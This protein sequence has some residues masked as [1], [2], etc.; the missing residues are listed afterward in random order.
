MNETEPA[1]Q[2]PDAQM[3]GR[4]VSHFEIREHLGRGGRGV[5][6]K[7]KDQKLDRWVALKFL[8]SHVSRDPL[9][10]KRMVNEARMASALD[11]PNICTIHAIDE[12]ADGQLFIAMAFY[13]GETL[14]ARI[15]RGPLSIAEIRDITLQ[16][17]SGLEAAHDRGIIH[18]DIKPANLML[19][20]DGVV[21][22]LDFGLSKPLSS[23]SKLT[24][25]GVLMGTIAYMSP[26]QAQGEEL[27]ARTDIWS[28]GVVLFEMATGRR[29]FSGNSELAVLMGIAFQELDPL[30]DAGNLPPSLLPVVTRAL[31]KD[32]DQRYP[33][34]AAMA[35][36][37]VSLDPEDDPRLPDT[38]TLE[39][40]AD[41]TRSAIFGAAARAR[42]QTAS[43]GLLT[44]SGP[45]SSPSAATPAPSTPAVPAAQRRRPFMAIAGAMALSALTLALLF[46]LLP[47]MGLLP[48]TGGTG[49]SGGRS[50][51]AYPARG[52]PIR[53][54]WLGFAP[55]AEQP[56]LAWLAPALTELVHLE[57]A[58]RRGLE[59]TSPENADE[60]LE[61]L[62]TREARA[63]GTS[64]GAQVAAET[65]PAASGASEPHWQLGGFYQRGVRDS[66]VVL[67]LTLSGPD[68]LPAEDPLA[69]T[70]DLDTLL[71]WPPELAGALGRHFGRD[72]TRNQ[73]AFA[74]L[75]GAGSA[76]EESEAELENL[77]AEGRELLRRFDG[78]AA[79]QVFAR[80]LETWP[81]EPWLHAGMAKAGHLLRDARALEHAERAFLLSEGF[82]RRKRLALLSLTLEIRGDYRAAAAMLSAPEELGVE[83]PG[84][85]AG[86][87]EDRDLRL[88]LALARTGHGD[89]ASEL[90]EG[91]DLTSLAEAD[92]RVPLAQA[93]IARSR[94]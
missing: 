68:G 85:K 62:R 2:S 27:D 53:L 1:S 59:V 38:R 90:L 94:S 4:T 33:D 13:E 54:H 21:K 32:R 7:A 60:L 87:W 10:K 6:Y 35:M 26:E 16:V 41:R 73:V 56:D 47:S 45:A 92:P 89:A 78:R 48:L 66:A 88:A 17:L 67:E 19:T 15:E 58:E 42:A 63:V 36:D 71:E 64:P 30:A 57:L 93:E 43:D 25:S 34:V 51:G 24:E 28:F 83:N 18:R 8:S 23:P 22:I 80:G 82:D 74:D 69:F 49:G 84:P 76:G 9:E 81:D 40:P 79:R 5:V 55:A 72:L 44:G 31:A 86:R 75:G 61:S 52:E 11:H 70:V 20:E 50:P 65:P 37:L 77:L 12:T 39:L 14:E 46:W 29:P 3:V 91:L